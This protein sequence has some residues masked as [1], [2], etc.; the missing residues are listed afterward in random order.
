M[1][2]STLRRR[3]RSSRRRLPLLAIAGVLGCENEIDTT[4]N[5]LNTGATDVVA[6]DVAA[7][8]CDCLAKGMVWRFDKLT[9]DSIDKKSHNVQIALNPLWKKDIAG[10]ELNFYAE[11]LEV[12]ATEVKVRIVNG[13][14]V[15]GSETD[16]CLLPYTSVE[17]TFPRDGCKLSPS[18]PAAMNVYAGTPA[19]PKNC[20]PTIDVPHSIPVRGAVLEALVSADCGRIDEGVVSAGHL[21]EPALAKTCTCLTTGNQN[22]EACGEPDQSFADPN[23]SADNPGCDGCN[24]KFQNLKTLLNNFGELEYLCKEGEDK[25]AC[26]TASFAG[27]KIDALPA[28]CA[29]F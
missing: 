11:V 15:V 5:N 20:A 3:L 19:N 23:K 24:N 29:G 9:L 26:L 10:N 27:A 16:I 12:S 21:P 13:A 25:A 22:S 7:G 28:T 18:A 6:A 8:A 2:T 14:R 1:P 17:V 4:P